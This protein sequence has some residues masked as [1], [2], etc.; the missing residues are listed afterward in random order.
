MT[1]VVDDPLLV[2]L[3]DGGAD[4]LDGDPI[5]LLSEDS[6][7]SKVIFDEEQPALNLL[8]GPGSDWEDFLLGEGGCGPLLGTI[9][10]GRR[11]EE[12]AL[13]LRDILTEALAASTPIVDASGITKQPHQPLPFERQSK[14]KGTQESDSNLILPASTCSSLSYSLSLLPETGA[15]RMET[16]PNTALPCVTSPPPPCGWTG[17][18]LPPNGTFPYFQKSIVSVKTTPEPAAEMHQVT[19]DLIGHPART[20]PDPPSTQKCHGTNLLHRLCAHGLASHSLGLTTILLDTVNR[21]L[22]VDPGALGRP[23]QVFVRRKVW[24]PPLAPSPPVSRVTSSFR[25]P[26]FLA[27][28]RRDTPRPLLQLL[29]QHSA[30]RGLLSLRDGLHDETPLLLLLR[31]RPHDAL[32]LNEVLAA[33]PRSAIIS[34]SHSNTVV[35][36]ACAW[37]APHS[38]VLYLVSVYP[39]ALEVRN[40]NGETPWDVAVSRT[41]TSEE[42]LRLLSPR[43]HR[44]RRRLL[45]RS[46]H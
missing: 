18:V 14:G 41:T 38:S 8:R 40:R 46:L 29:I 11:R 34:D 44:F 3:V 23:G 1:G 32:L 6:F 35:H 25:Y 36:A 45:G 26:L 33:D 4:S 7:H 16:R 20:M 2:C 13:N 39:G 22:R 42:V 21:L 9:Q 15:T 24:A 30:Q 10:G 28:Q 5:M 37:G 43:G 17:L 19:F 31:K 27:L 12:V